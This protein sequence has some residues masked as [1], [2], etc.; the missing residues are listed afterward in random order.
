MCIIDYIVVGALLLSFILFVSVGFYQADQTKNLLSASRYA[1]SYVDIQSKYS[2]MFSDRISGGTINYFT[3]LDI[4]GKDVV[5]TLESFDI[6][7]KFTGVINNFV[8]LYQLFIGLTFSIFLIGIFISKLNSQKVLHLIIQLIILLFIYSNIKSSNFVLI[9]VL[10]V[11]LCASLGLTYRY[12][13][14]VKLENSAF[15]SIY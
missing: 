14:K 1:V 12:H 7:M 9:I 8:T 3:F 6:Y 4:S 11:L 13:R 5:K 10:Q 15:S 2:G